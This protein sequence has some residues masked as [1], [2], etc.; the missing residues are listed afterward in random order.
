VHPPS[1]MLQ[2]LLALENF[3][4]SIYVSIMFYKTKTK[5][6]T[7]TKLFVISRWFYGSLPSRFTVLL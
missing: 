5:T 6:K 4:I 2:L 7:K 3:D 1:G